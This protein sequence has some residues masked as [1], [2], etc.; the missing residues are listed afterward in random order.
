MLSLH[1]SYCENWQVMTS[2]L[3]LD[4]ITIELTIS[5]V[6]FAGVECLCGV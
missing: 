3:M 1:G 5:Y 6:R 2:V 4:E